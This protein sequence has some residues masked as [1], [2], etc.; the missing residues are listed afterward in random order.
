MHD[1]FGGAWASAAEGWYRP[2]PHYLEI[3]RSMLRLL[4]MPFSMP[5]RFVLGIPA[6]AGEDLRAGEIVYRRDDRV[7]C[8]KPRAVLFRPTYHI[9]DEDIV[10]DDLDEEPA[11]T[12]PPR[13]VMIVVAV[14]GAIGTAV[15]MGVL[16][17][18]R[19]NG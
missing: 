1:D 4:A 3:Q 7:V 5:P 9:R 8:R 10:D 12:P 18:Q 16:W 19:W 6:R 13:W 14:L 11:P 17:Y 15:S 2:E